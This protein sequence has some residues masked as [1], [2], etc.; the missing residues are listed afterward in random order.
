MRST[1][2]ILD[3]LFTGLI[4]VIVDA[5]TGGWWEL[6]P[7]DVT[8][9]LERADDSVDG[10]VAIEISISKSKD[11]PGLLMVDATAPVQIELITQ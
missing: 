11:S 1:S 10:P 6:S 2:L 4:G 9:T 8:I 5:A 3:I 7:D